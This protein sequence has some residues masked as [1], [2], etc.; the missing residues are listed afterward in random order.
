MS[1]PGAAGDAKQAEVAAVVTGPGG[2]GGSAQGLAGGG[3]QPRTRRRPRLLVVVLV[4]LLGLAAGLGLVSPYLR[5]W[6]HLRAA[7]SA[8]D[9]YH[10]PQAVHHLQACLRVWPENP[11][12]LLMSARAA[13]R[14]GAYDEAERGLEKYRR[15]RGVDDAGSFEELLLTA[16]RAVDQAAPLCRRQVEQDHPDSPL[17][18]EALARGYMR[19]YRLG[20]AHLCLDFW[21]EKQP[22]NPQALCLKG[23]FHL[24]Y[25]RAPDR[26]VESYRRAVELD[27][28]HEEARQGLAIVLLESKSFAE[29]AGHLEQL[30]RSQPDNL[31]VQ[32]GLAECRNGM[33]KPD[34]ARR[35]VDDVLSRQPDNAPALALR[36][37]LAVQNGQYAEAENW[38][39]QAVSRAP[40]NHQ[41][42]YSLILC[43][44]QTGQSEEAQRR[45]KELRQWEEDAKRFNEIVTR[46]MP[47]NPQD[48]EL[49][50]QL[51]QLLLR[52]GHPEEGLR[53]LHG[54]LRLDPGY[55]PAR[56]ALTEYYKKADGS[57]QQ[58]EP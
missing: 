42:R 57:R 38:L 25:E 50:L 22:D 1:A 10:N 53:W 19:Q 40:A 46:D 9:S 3:T 23:Q 34:E 12:V 39:R 30:R 48:P 6:Y 43:L 26:A 36:G 28:E 29:A 33:G 55:E 27:P 41:A 17:I 51:G 7:R 15:A 32:V 18:L 20:E 58:P 16:E 31:R 52:S 37:Q 13:R 14:A 56:Q 2:P 4:P 49:H 24:D 11:E 47:K 8:L 21:L 45:E 35:L 44:V 5:G 54:A